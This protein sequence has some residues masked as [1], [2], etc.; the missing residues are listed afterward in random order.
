[1]RLHGEAERDD[2]MQSIISMI[3]ARRGKEKGSAQG[4]V[5]V[6]KVERRSAAGARKCTVR[7]LA[8]REDVVEEI[9][10]LRKAEKE[11][12]MHMSIQ[13]FVPAAA[14]ATH[15]CLWRRSRDLVVQCLQGEGGESEWLIGSFEVSLVW[16]DLER[17]ATHDVL[18]FLSGNGMLAAVQSVVKCLETTQRRKMTE[19]AVDLAEEAPGRWALVAIKGY[20]L[21][22]KSPSKIKPA[23][24]SF[25]KSTAESRSA[26]KRRAATRK[27]KWKCAGKFC[28]LTADDFVC[29]PPSFKIAYKSIATFRADGSKAPVNA[30]AKRDMNRMYD[31]VNVCQACF[32]IYSASRKRIEK[33]EELEK[34]K[35]RVARQ[36]REK[37]RESRRK[38]KERLEKEKKMK[39][40]QRQQ[41]KNAKAERR[42]R[43]AAAPAAGGGGPSTVAGTTT[44][45]ATGRSV[46]RVAKVAAERV[47]DKAAKAKKKE[48][49][50]QDKLRQKQKKEAMSA[51]DIYSEVQLIPG[52]RQKKKK[53]FVSLRSK[54][55][56]AMR[57]RSRVRR[58][59]GVG[60]EASGW[61][62]RR[63]GG[64]D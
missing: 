11:P 42:R 27:P 56:K 63:G 6:L 61:R 19:L 2:A 41:K 35:R 17:A 24:A 39:S 32:E 22:S 64:L 57:A 12:R 49:E 29:D 23:P 1:M 37:E 46:P 18:F 36:E 59:G 26:A 58:G 55:A 15:R 62:R 33:E 45:A 38:E 50:E 60:V 51:K 9:K 52:E 31:L 25:R 30:M 3:C 34:E 54:H 8:T 28:S 14:E 48:K 20:K 16:I 13:R 21:D 10:S 7:R 43:A 40:K 44:N 5:A 47:A 4:P 53:K